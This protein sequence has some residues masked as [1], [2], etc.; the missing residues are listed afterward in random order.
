MGPTVR[1]RA[2]SKWDRGRRGRTQSGLTESKLEINW[3]IRKWNHL[4][5]C[6]SGRKDECKA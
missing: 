5:I 4:G 2:P 1:Q 3:L 6:L